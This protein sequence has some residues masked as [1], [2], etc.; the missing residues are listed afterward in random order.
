MFTKILV[1]GLVLGGAAALASMFERSQARALDP[2]AQWPVC[3]AA[4]N[5]CQGMAMAPRISTERA[6]AMLAH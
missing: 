1:C 6:V 4:N 2:V 3:D 5:H